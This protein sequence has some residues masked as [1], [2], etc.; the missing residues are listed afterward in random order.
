VWRDRVG[1]DDLKR[2]IKHVLDQWNPSRVLIENAHHGPPLAAELKDYHAELISASSG[3]KGESGKPG[4]LER[5]TKLL[6]KLANGEV[7]L[8]QYNNQWLPELE[9]EWLA[10]TGMEEE[11]SDQVDAAAYA[12][13]HAE[14]NA[15]AS[16]GGL[17]HSRG[18]SSFRAFQSG[19]NQDPVNILNRSRLLRSHRQTG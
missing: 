6:N 10:W 12:A 19:W 7:F 2:S 9:A 18:L 15:H 1:W 11:T 17:V 5:A 8:P 14:S 4:K 3:L 16:W 13:R